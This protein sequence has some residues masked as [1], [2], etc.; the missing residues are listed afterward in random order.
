MKINT[1]IRILL[2]KPNN[3]NICGL[4][5]GRTSRISCG[6]KILNPICHL[7]VPGSSDFE[8]LAVVF[9]AH[10]YRENKKQVYLNGKI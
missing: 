10:V 3:N 5:F 8:D 4:Q 7:V 2:C 9:S 1:R 6:R